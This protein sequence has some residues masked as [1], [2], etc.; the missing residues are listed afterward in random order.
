MGRFPVGRMGFGRPV[1]LDQ[2]ETRRI[3]L[4]LEHVEAGDS[5]LAPA[6]LG[7]GPGGRL[8]RFDAIGLNMN[9][10]LEDM[11][12]VGEDTLEAA[13]E[14]VNQA[15]LPEGGQGRITAA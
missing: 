2:L 5:R 15:A 11:H 7:V 9:V 12:S 6:G 4:L 14:R 13:R 3:V 10:D 1:D 8:E